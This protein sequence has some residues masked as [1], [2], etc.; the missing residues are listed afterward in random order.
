LVC[1]F[2]KWFGVCARRSGLGVEARLV[3]RIQRVL[4]QCWHDVES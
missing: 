2:S 3:R 1:G 4:A